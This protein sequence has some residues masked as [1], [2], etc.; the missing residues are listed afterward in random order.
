MENNLQKQVREITEKL[1]QG[2]RDLF[3]SDKYKNY[4][5]TM[6]KFHNYSFNNVVLIAMQKP[7]ANL[8]AGYNAW[9]KIHHR[10]VKKGEKAI[11]ILAPAPYTIKTLRDKIDPNT[12]KQILDNN[13]V[14]V[15]EEIEIKKPAFKVV[16]VFDISQTEGKELPT[17]GVDELQGKVEKYDTLFDA[18]KSV[19]PVPVGFEKISSGAKGYYHLVDKRITINEGMSE[20]HNLKTLIHEIAHAKL[21]D[22]DL[23][24]PEEQSERPDQRTREVQAESVAY[25]ICQHYGL[26]TSD[27]SFSYIATWGSGQNMTE[28]KASL[29]TIRKT[30]SEMINEIDTYMQSLEQSI[31]VRIKQPGQE[32]DSQ[33][34]TITCEWSE[35]PAFEDGKKY[36]VLEFDELM[37][38]TDKEWCVGQKEELDR[39]GSFDAAYESGEAKYLGYRKVKFTVNLPE[40][41]LPSSITERQ[42]I[43]DG[44][45]GVIDFFKM[46]PGHKYSNIVKS[47]ET[48]KAY[49][50]EKKNLPTQSPEKNSVLKRLNQNKEKLQNDSNELHNMVH[51]KEVER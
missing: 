1:E 14:P 32:K 50:I 48:A 2:I 5:N 19:S 44:Y 39:Y 47:L 30:A 22:I 16:N 11:K 36:S 40:G 6:S 10:Q 20:L 51:K 27:Y 18:I 15:Q 13:G 21:H 43:G 35:H 3:E 23:S 8:I 49:E 9:Q 42:D 46:F 33:I 34:T 17:I 45:G 41:N 12:H 37:R 7:D 29:D 28:L 31:D 4:L 38:K 25:V 26:D 24:I